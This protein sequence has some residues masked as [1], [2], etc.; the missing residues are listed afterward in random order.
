VIDVLGNHEF[1]GQRWPEH[2]E[3]VR[4]QAHGSPVHVLENDSVIIHGVRFLG[5][6][7]STS[8]R[9]YGEG[10]AVH[11]RLVA[12]NAMHDY[13]TIRRLD[14]SRLTP[15]TAAV[16]PH[17]RHGGRRREGRAGCRRGVRSRRPLRSGPV[18]SPGP[19]GARR[20]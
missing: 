5:A 12:P 20:A 11:S 18:G 16:R 14:G 19:R 15:W 7:L 4:E 10:R 8:F 6:T 2:V 13:D 17:P 1:Y 3:N 9:L